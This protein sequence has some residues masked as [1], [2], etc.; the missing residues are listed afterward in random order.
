MRKIEKGFAETFIARRSNVGND[1]RRD[2]VR[3]VAN[4]LGALFQAG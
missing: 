2:R 3:R 4:V 1:D